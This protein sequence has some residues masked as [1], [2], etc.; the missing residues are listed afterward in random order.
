MAGGIQWK[1]EHPSNK[2]IQIWRAGCLNMMADVEAKAQFNA[3]V[4]T[5]ALRNSA[6]LKAT[7]DGAEVTFGTDG[8]KTKGK[9]GGGRVDYALLRH[10]VNHKHPSTVHY[11][12]KAAQE[13]ANS[14][15]GRYFK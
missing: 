13:V 11:L 10:E 6:R 12:A 1:G 8:P 2:F 14:D 4:L 15:I 9:D 3:P 7:R 5:G